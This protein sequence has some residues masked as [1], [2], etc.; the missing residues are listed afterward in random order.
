MDNNKPLFTF[1]HKQ[2]EKFKLT[3]NINK[4][5]CTKCQQN[6][7]NAEIK[8]HKNFVNEVETQYEKNH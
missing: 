5:V 7:I 6:S 2:H 3:S 1:K 8:R 4:C